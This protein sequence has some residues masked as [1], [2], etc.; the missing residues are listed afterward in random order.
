MSGVLRIRKVSGGK[1]VG[2]VTVHIIDDTV[3]ESFLFAVN[4]RIGS[5]VSTWNWGIASRVSCSTGEV[6]YSGGF[7]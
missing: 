1:Y 5:D 4:G 2:D 3:A 6:G 7:L